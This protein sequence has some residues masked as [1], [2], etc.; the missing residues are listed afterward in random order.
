MGECIVCIWKAYSPCYQCECIICPVCRNN[1]SG[2]CSI[3]CMYDLIFD[4][5]YDD[6]VCDLLDKIVINH[7]NDDTFYSLIYNSQ[8]DRL[9][10]IKSQNRKMNTWIT[11]F[12][13]QY[14]INDLISIII[15]Y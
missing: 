2:L 14:L 8:V 12:L 15:N 9:K 4:R 3:N 6:N 13:K 1:A 5:L 10:I 7:K 11:I